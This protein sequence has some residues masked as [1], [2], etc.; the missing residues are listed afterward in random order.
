MCDRVQ[1]SDKGSVS[2]H[3]SPEG[4]FTVTVTVSSESGHGKL[5][6]RQLTRKKGLKEVKTYVALQSHRCFLKVD[7]SFEGAW[8]DGWMVSRS[9]PHAGKSIGSFPKRKQNFSIAKRFTY[10]P[11]YPA[12]TE[13]RRSITSFSVQTFRCKINGW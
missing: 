8:M 5:C 13:V 6:I 7:V 3:N 11:V 4:F 10:T 12:G 2:I 9:F 1:R